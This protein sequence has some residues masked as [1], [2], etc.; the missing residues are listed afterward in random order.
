MFNSVAARESARE[1]VIAKA[2]AHL[3]RVPQVDLV[4]EIDSITQ[5]LLGL[6]I[7]AL[8]AQINTFLQPETILDIERCSETGDDGERYTFTVVS[9]GA[10]RF[11]CES[12]AQDPVSV[13]SDPAELVWVAQ[14]LSVDVP[15]ALAELEFDDFGNIEADLSAEQEAAL[16]AWVASPAF[17]LLCNRLVILH[18]RCVGCEPHRAVFLD[19]RLQEIACPTHQAPP[20]GPRAE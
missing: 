6:K 18:R 20:R 4:D 9:I 14:R 3:G 13:V 17:E 11:D 1:R 5:E 12:D 7:K 19:G 15:E 10:F 16:D 2:L 8:D